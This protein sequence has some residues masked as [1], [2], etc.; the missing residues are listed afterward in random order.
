MAMTFNASVALSAATP[1]QCLD[2]CFPSLWLTAML[3]VHTLF[4]PL[5]LLARA[6]VGELPKPSGTFNRAERFVKLQYPLQNQE[7]SP[8]API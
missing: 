4:R 6:L 3:G 5:G 8:A 2:A 1:K 7:A